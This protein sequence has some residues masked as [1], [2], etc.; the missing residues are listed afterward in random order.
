MATKF[1]HPSFLLSCISPSLP[2]SMHALF[3]PD[4]PTADKFSNCH[5]PLPWLPNPFLALTL[6]SFDFPHSDFSSQLPISVAT[7][8]KFMATEEQ[9]RVNIKHKEDTPG[10][11]DR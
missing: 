10:S 2:S 9:Q 11:A 7:F 1:C 4:P 6:P 8:S 5:H 3:S